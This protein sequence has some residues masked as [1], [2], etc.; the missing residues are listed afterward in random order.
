[1]RRLR[2]LIEQDPNDPNAQAPAPAGAAP[3]PEPQIPDEMLPPGPEAKPEDLP[4]PTQNNK[5]LKKKEE[6]PENPPHYRTV[7]TT[8]AV[9]PGGRPHDHD[10]KIDQNGDGIARGNEGH[11]HIVVNFD[12]QPARGH[13]HKLIDPETRRTIG[14]KG[15]AFK[16]GTD[17]KQDAS[18]KPPMASPMTAA[19]GGGG[20][21][22]A[23]LPGTFSSPDAAIQNMWAD[24]TQ[25]PLVEWSD[26]A[27]LFKKYDV[28]HRIV[29]EGDRVLDI[30]CGRGALYEWFISGFKK[31]IGY[32]GLDNR[33]E[34]MREFMERFP[35]TSNRLMVVETLD[36]SSAEELANE[37]RHFAVATLFG[38]PATI[39]NDSK[40]YDRLGKIAKFMG[41]VADTVVIECVDRVF[42]SPEAENDERT[43]WSVGEVRGLFGSDW[44]TFVVR[45]LTTEDFA[46]VAYRRDIL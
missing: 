12:V 13:T 43:A 42:H 34:L 35:E 32:Y 45:P 39:P 27:E 1:M 19:Q 14:M 10:A 29:Q 20:G 9:S 23:G 37:H 22:G 38:L 30:G 7:K 36:E 5:L 24:W 4:D 46:V 21:P 26:K 6:D 31:P 40:K 15:S 11:M 33:Q 8:I 25:P 44:Q 3:A 16:S 17:N 18:Q 28:L 41:R 2:P